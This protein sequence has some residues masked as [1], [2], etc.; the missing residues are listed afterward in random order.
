M[1]NMNRLY[2]LTLI[3]LI[4]CGN[5]DQANST[6]PK[7]PVKPKIVDSVPIDWVFNKVDS[8]RLLFSNG[9]IVET[10][11]FN[12]TYIGQIALAHKAPLLIFS[13]RECQGCDANISMYMHSPSDSQLEVEFGKNRYKCPGKES[14]YFTNKLFYTSRAFYGQV[15]K[16]TKGVIWFENRL[17]GNGHW[18][19]DVF[20]SWMDHDIRRDT[21][22]HN[23]SDLNQT[24]EL[25]KEGLCQEIKGRQYKSEP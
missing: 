19:H 3:L 18:D 22:Y 10:N 1:L 12:L 14:D 8:T 9:K 4:G 11:L 5:R 17:M 7:P 21:M 24:L 25:L 20:L 15:L 23:S 16:N 6:L 2:L 13:G